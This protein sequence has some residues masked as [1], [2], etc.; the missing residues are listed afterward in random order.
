MYSASSLSGL[1]KKQ[2]VLEVL[3]TLIHGCER[4]NQAELNVDI[5]GM[6]KIHAFTQLKQ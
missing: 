1:I 4:E 6:E 5:T 2:E 3:Y